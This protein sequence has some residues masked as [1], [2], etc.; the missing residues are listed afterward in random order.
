MASQKRKFSAIEDD[1]D[2]VTPS[3]TSS[4]SGDLSKF[5]DGAMTRH[6]VMPVKQLRNVFQAPSTMPYNIEDELTTSFIDTNGARHSTCPM[7]RVK[8]Q[9]EIVIVAPSS[10]AKPW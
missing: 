3:L 10:D 9:H 2:E 6:D 4:H 1:D 8:Q 7:S 5:S